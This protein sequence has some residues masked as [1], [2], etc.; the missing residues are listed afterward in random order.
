MY[1]SDYHSGLRVS[2]SRRGKRL[3]SAY[4]DRHCQIGDADSELSGVAD[5]YFL[6]KIKISSYISDN[7]LSGAWWQ[8]L[9][10]LGGHSLACLM[11]I[12]MIY[13]KADKDVEEM[14]REREHSKLF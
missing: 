13:I 7:F 12:N 2:I 10:T 9:T 11:K 14:L 3:T 1:A 6:A 8:T 5:I 4:R